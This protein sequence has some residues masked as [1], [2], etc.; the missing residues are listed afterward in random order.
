M[1][2]DPD[3][4]KH[5]PASKEIPTQ[6]GERLRRLMSAVQA[7]DNTE[8]KNSQ[9]AGPKSGQPQVPTDQGQPGPS[10]ETKPSQA[11][12]AFPPAD[13]SEQNTAWEAEGDL[14]FPS[15]SSL[16]QADTV[17]PPNVASFLPDL[18]YP[19]PPN[20][21]RAE[22][23]TPPPPP[24]GT[25]GTP[26]PRRVDEFDI[27]ATRVSPVSYTPPPRATSHILPRSG[28]P[29]R[30]KAQPV[31]PPVERYFSQTPP[32]PPPPLQVAEAAAEPGSGNW[33]KAFGCLLRLTIITLFIA[34]IV[35]V[36]AGSFLVYQYFSIAS[37]LPSVEDLRTHASQF[38]TTRILDRNKNVLYEVIDPNAGRR[39]YV[40]LDK[41][42]PY[43]IATTIATEDKDYY[44]NPGFDPLA[45]L[46][47]LW[48]NYTSGN[49]VSGASTIT[50]QL[51]RALLL[52][53]AERTEQT[54]QRKAREIVLASEITRR[55]SKQEILELYFNEI[56]YGNLAYGVEAASETYFNTTADKL[57]LGQAAFL[58]GLPQAPSVYDIF[59]NRDATLVR[60]K[61]VLV[62][63]YQD[64]AEKQC[65]FV[66][67]TAQPVCIDATA[68]TTA[69][70]EIEQYKFKVQENNMRYPHWVNYIIAQLTAT[71]GAETIYRS[72]FT[73]YTTLDPGLQDQAE[74]IVKAQVDALAG[75]NVQDGALVAMRPSTGEILAMVGSADFNNDAISGQINMALS[76]RQPGSS[77]KPLTYTAAFE[78]GWTPATLIWDVPSEF[79]P[80]GNADDTRPPYV[81]VNYDGNFHGPV[82]V[83]TA[84]ANSYNIPAVKT[85]QFV[86]IYPNQAGPNKPGLIS[87]AQRMGITTLT[88]SDY[89]LS[90]TLGGGEV[91]LLELTGA[92]GVFADSGRKMPPV[93]ITK[94]VDYTG[95]VVF[96]YKPPAGDQVISPEH[97]YLMTSILSD[98][99]ARTPAFG[100][101]SVLNLPFPVA[102]KTGTTNDFRDNWTLGYTPDLVVGTWIGNADYTPMIH[103]TGVSGAAPIWAAFFKQAETD[104]TGGHPTPFTRP[105]GIVERVVCELSGTEPS[106]W[107]P[108][109]HNEIF[110]SDQLPPK[111]EN[112]LWQQIKIDTWTGLK[113]SSA[114]SEFTEQAMV[115]NVTD[116]WAIKWLQNTDDGKAW[117]QNAGFPDPIVF[118][119]K[120]ECTADDPHATL[121]L[122][123]LDDGQV[124]TSVPLDIYAMAD[125]TEG[126]KQFSLQYGKGSKPGDWKTIKDGFKS[127]V[128]QPQNIYSWDMKGVKYTDISL[129]I[130]L[131][132]DNGGYANKQ[133]HLVLNLPTPTPVPTRTP[134]VTRTPRPTPTDIPLPTDTPEPPTP[135]PAPS[136]TPSSLQTQQPS[137][138]GRGH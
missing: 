73:V 1:S 137:H 85:L 130:H 125:A 132:G 121:Q 26:L 62:L 93:S 108:T 37:A 2:N 71:Y 95:T 35:A 6:P 131:D 23:P 72:G 9:S 64:S 21:R 22:D 123:G 52:T 124:I 76:P 74:Q 40:T 113:A 138:P 135:V 55:Y 39:T 57:T 56:Y 27:N 28:Q 106:Q 97:A 63:A 114:C 8:Q 48:Q 111:K 122:P 68:A 110:A 128:K 117:A 67:D 94:I 102:V 3:N 10:D 16:D 41:I 109:Q 77:I 101:N 69:A 91:T 120:R 80:S 81:P 115:A 89:G 78:L 13:E 79:P 127:P 38:E 17:P 82:S 53:S 24:G 51:A 12:P 119:P 84:I 70:Q 43:L 90:L 66:A 20:P 112:D 86:G 36:G 105:A 103:S 126:F 4:R 107:C 60:Q 19:T 29:V 98:N 134:T 100:A 14:L 129:R 5:I 92:Y 136:D 42:S 75:Q 11:Q 99:N 49:V 15:D 32:P 25:S 116:P 96:E 104:L 30:P 34:V 7:E 31:Q 46:R 54:V 58:A 61:Q 18:N 88:R 45:I 133:V 44:T 83:R 118:T 50:Q 87:F 33:K 65:I 59:T 47:A